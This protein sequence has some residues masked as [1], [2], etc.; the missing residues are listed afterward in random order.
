MH[1]MQE[2]CS[3]IPGVKKISAEECGEINDLHPQRKKDIGNQIAE[4]FITI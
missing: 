1:A 2:K 4:V 3:E